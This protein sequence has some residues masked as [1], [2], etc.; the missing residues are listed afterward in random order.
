MWKTVNDRGNSNRQTFARILWK[1]SGL[2]HF[3]SLPPLRLLRKSGKGKTDQKAARWNINS[4]SKKMSVFKRMEEI[5]DSNCTSVFCNKKKVVLPS[6]KGQYFSWKCHLNP[7]LWTV[8]IAQAEI[9]TTFIPP[10]GAF[11]TM[12][13]KKNQTVPYEAFF[14]RRNSFTILPVSA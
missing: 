9:L 4:S 5:N 6:W 13:R 10:L 12:K 1:I 2:F 8:E 14:C 7:L 11:P 3:A